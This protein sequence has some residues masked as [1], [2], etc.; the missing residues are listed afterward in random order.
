MSRAREAIGTVLV[1]AALGYALSRIGFSSWDEVHRMFVFADL[2]MTLVFASGVALL[3]PAWRLL[4]RVQ[5]VTWPKRGIHKGT[6]A[7]G[8]LFGIGWALCGACPSIAFVQLGEGQVAA[9]A[10]IGGIFLG[11]YVYS[12]V[13]ERFFR[14]DVGSCLDE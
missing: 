1:G 14:W 6:L 9:L 12:V 11:N 5:G 4:G 7:G 13:H 3:F 10:T 8:L 2:R